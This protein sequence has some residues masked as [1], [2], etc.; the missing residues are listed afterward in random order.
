MTPL[1]L[2]QLHKAAD[3]I[4][5]VPAGVDFWPIE[6][7]EPLLIGVVFPFL[8]FAPWQLKGSPKMLALGRE[9]S[10]MWKNEQVDA[11]RVLREFCAL[12]RRLESM[13][14]DVVR[15]VLYFRSK[16]GVPYL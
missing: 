9:L 12:R 5:T 6:M 8:S 2:K 10:G 16:A 11:G 13:P 4:F 3:L 1:W 14:R 15:R 7:H